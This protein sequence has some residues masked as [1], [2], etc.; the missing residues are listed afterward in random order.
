[1]ADPSPNNSPAVVLGNP[2]PVSNHLNS[3]PASKEEPQDQMAI[4]PALAPLPD[5][6]D[7]QLDTIMTDVLVS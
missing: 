7:T 2:E 1:M 3:E 4:P 5:L 6:I